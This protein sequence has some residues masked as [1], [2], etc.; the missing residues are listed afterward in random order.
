MEQELDITN[1]MLGPRRASVFLFRIGGNSMRDAGILDGDIVIVDRALEAR[2]G[3]IVVASINGEYTCKYYRLLSGEVWL[4][5]ANPEFGPIKV[6]EEMGLEIFGRYDG[7]L[8][9]EHPRN[10]KP[11]RTTNLES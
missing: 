2:N 9:K 10:T 8:R 7:L 5:A 11:F 4:V 3:D 6:T 1:Y